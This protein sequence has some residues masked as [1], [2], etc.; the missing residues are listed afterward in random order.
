[1]TN[2]KL[3]FAIMSADVAITAKKQLVFYNLMAS[4]STNNDEFTST[5][6][7]LNVW[8]ADDLIDFS[9]YMPVN[10]NKNENA[11]TPVVDTSRW[12]ADTLRILKHINEK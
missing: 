11:S 4:A 7:N 2:K 10:I 8:A 9:A 1:L 3:P 12:D 5:F 6:R